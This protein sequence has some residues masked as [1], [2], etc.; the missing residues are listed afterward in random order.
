MTSLA[1]EQSL[2]TEL[3]AVAAVPLG[4]ERLP[5]VRGGTVGEVEP[6]RR[7]APRVLLVDQ[8]GAAGRAIVDGLVSEGYLVEIAID[9]LDG[10]RRFTAK[11]H[12]VVIMDVEPPGVA[13]A[14]VSRRMRAV[15][16]VPVILA[17]TTGRELDRV[18]TLELGAA[19]RV[20]K[21]YRLPD[22]VARIE[23]VLRLPGPPAPSMDGPWA[24]VAV[25]RDGMTVGALRVDFAAREVT[26][27]GRSVHL[28]R[29]EFD[30]LALLLSPPGQLRTRAELVQRLWGGRCIPGSRTLDTHVRRLRMKLE[31]DP[32]SPRHLATVRGVGFRFDLGTDGAEGPSPG[33]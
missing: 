10:L 19:E 13:G 12:D 5:E 7:S 15:A 2:V 23:G 24:A 3:V 8:E 28:P 17:T 1:S 14:E 9:L 32:A 4:L 16:P 21:P 18:R 6:H 33:G 20:S 11:P 22:L 25:Q 26:R 31:D 30:L 27:G 29:R